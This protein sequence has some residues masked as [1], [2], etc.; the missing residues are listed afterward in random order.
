MKKR[1]REREVGVGGEGM[2]AIFGSL[3]PLWDAETAAAAA[4]AKATASSKLGTQR[5]CSCVSV[6]VS[7][8]LMTCF[9]PCLC[10]PFHPDPAQRKRERER[11]DKVVYRPPLFIPSSSVHSSLSVSLYSNL[12]ASCSVS[13]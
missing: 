8:P 4:V 1:G 7:S 2:S 3:S 5:G 6:A 12:P 11:R 9:L 13:K 10:K